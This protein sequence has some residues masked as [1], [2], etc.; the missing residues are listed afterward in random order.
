MADERIFGILRRLRGFGTTI[1]L[2]P[3]RNY[4]EIQRTFKEAVQGSAEPRLLRQ[5]RAAKS[6]RP[7]RNRYLTRPWPA[8]AAG[9]EAQG[10]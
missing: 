6:R 9:I 1:L 5:R 3:R 8:E 10:I 7:A 4:K 2:R